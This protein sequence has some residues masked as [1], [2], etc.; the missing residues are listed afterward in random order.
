MHER[1][2]DRAKAQQQSFDSYVREAA[3]GDS[4]ADQL[5]KLSNLKDQ[6]VLTND[7]FE[8][9]KAKLLSA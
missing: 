5:T 8:A 3:T 9:Q 6:G 7:E 2:I 4:I 1:Q